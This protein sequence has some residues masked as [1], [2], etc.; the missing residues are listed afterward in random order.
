MAEYGK[1]DKLWYDGTVGAYEPADEPADGVHQAVYDD[2]T[3]QWESLYFVRMRWRFLDP[4]ANQRKRRVDFLKA[5]ANLDVCWI[6]RILRQGAAATSRAPVCG[7]QH[8][9]PPSD[10]SSW[11]GWNIYGTYLLG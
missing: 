3:V 7:V 9:S 10:D 4:K 1:G 11:P 5:A 6:D 8:D 2:E